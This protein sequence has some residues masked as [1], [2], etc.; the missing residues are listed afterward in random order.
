MEKFYNEDSS[1]NEDNELSSGNNKGGTK[2]NIT[3]N[4]HDDIIN[5]DK[6]SN[7]YLVFVLI[8]HFIILICFLLHVN[9]QSMM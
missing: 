3:L 4:N 6:G 9:N 5:C 1:Q 8:C 2:R 7:F